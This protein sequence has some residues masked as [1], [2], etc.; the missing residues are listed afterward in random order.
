MIKTKNIYFAF[1]LLVASSLFWSGN[2]FTGK[3]A[4]I[5]ELAPFKLSFLR[6]TLAFLL[7]LPFT[8]HK[9]IQDFDKYKKNLPYL[10][11]DARKNFGSQPLV[12]HTTTICTVSMHS[13]PMKC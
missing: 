13:Q 11:F 1:I 4:S 5:Y 12:N 8:Y 3:I 6:W 10:F 9:I 7:L 2:F